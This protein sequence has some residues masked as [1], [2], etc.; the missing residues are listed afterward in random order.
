MT[1]DKSAAINRREFGKQMGALVVGAT[2]A[3]SE[4]SLRTPKN[5]TTYF[6]VNMKL[7]AEVAG[8]H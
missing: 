7:P 8:I 2:F 1:G 3:T 4:V 5:R 6:Q